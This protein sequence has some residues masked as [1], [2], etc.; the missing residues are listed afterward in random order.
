MTDK[1]REKLVSYED[2]KTGTIILFR[3]YDSSLKNQWAC[4]AREIRLVRKEGGFIVLASNDHRERVDHISEPYQRMHYKKGL[5]KILTQK[6]LL[7]Y[8]GWYK[9]KYFE[10]VLK[11]ENIVL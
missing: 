9:G 5:Q 8:M 3:F 7:L 4:T 6:D 2:Y 10:S 11:G 1:Q